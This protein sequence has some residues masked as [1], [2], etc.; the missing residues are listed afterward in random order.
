MK[1]EDLPQ[2]LSAL[3]KISKEICYVTDKSG[4][5]ITVLSRG[6]DIK[7]TALNAAWDEIEAR[8]AEAKQKV[9]EKKASPLLV[10]MEKALMDI[11]ILSAYSGFSKLQIKRH[12]K[13]KTFE[14]LTETKLQ[15]YAEI[16]NISIFDLKNMQVNET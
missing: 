14:S 15:K 6:W 1:K 12:L 5:Y 3:G 10:F 4:K 13:P 2:D 8:I 9:L 7:I 11:G 16:F